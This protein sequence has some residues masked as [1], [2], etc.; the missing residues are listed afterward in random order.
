[1]L[2]NTSIELHTY[3]FNLFEQACR[4]EQLA[5]SLELE[6]LVLCEDYEPSG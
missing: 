2:D 5:R 4:Q 3:A 6:V 1:M